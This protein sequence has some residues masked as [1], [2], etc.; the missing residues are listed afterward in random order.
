MQN[1]VS[2]EPPIFGGTSYMDK[3]WKLLSLKVIQVTQVTRKVQASEPLI[4]VLP[5]PKARALPIMWG[6]KQL[7]QSPWQHPH[8]QARDKP[9]IPLPPSFLS[10]IS[11]YSLRASPIPGRTFAFPS[12]VRW[13]P[14]PSISSFPSIASVPSAAPAVR[15]LHHWCVGTFHT[16]GQNLPSCTTWKWF[17]YCDWGSVTLFSHL[18]FSFLLRSV[19][20]STSYQ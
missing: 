17:A 11:F 10:L 15:N 20:I 2:E 14:A 8:A 13:D 5:V 1:S 16:S 19:L 6:P 7:V 4:W 12:H 9:S 3:P 18:G